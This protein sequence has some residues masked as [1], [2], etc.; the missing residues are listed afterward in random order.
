VNIAGAV[1]GTDTTNVRSSLAATPASVKVTAN[2]G[3]A[4][5]KIDYAIGAAKDVAGHLMRIRMRVNNA[6]DYKESN[7]WLR[8]GGNWS[9]FRAGKFHNAGY[10]STDGYWVETW[11]IPELM[12]HV[13]GTCDLAAVDLIRVGSTLASA[14]NAHEYVIDDISFF[15]RAT[16]TPRHCIVLDDGKSTAFQVAC[17][18]AAKGVR[19]T[20]YVIPSYVG[21]S[22]FMT[23]AQ[24]K[25][26]QAMGHLIANHSYA[27]LEWSTGPMTLAA[28]V[29]DILDGSKWLEDNGFARGARHFALPGGTANWDATGMSVMG[30]YCDTL[31]I[32][33]NHCNDYQP[34]TWGEIL[35]TQAFDNA[36]TAGTVLTNGITY[37]VDTIVGFHS[38]TESGIRTFID[39]VAAA[40]DAGTVE[41]VT[42]DQL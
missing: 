33:G 10:F 36:T 7:V 16:R 40:Q 38:G 35:C 5:V 29:A 31:R 28:R 11:R 42:V 3:S 30:T 20:F 32:T 34:P 4:E 24:L 27:H 26:L 12:S 37:G 14:N 17:Y 9:Q 19:A 22:A 15:T 23:L 6:T 1:L 41:A 21:R 39:A 13:V 2:A 18:M 8:S 25:E